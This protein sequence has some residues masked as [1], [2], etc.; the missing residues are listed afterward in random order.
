MKKISDEEH[1]RNI[2]KLM[3]SGTS[4]EDVQQIH[5]NAKSLKK[6]YSDSSFVIARS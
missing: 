1:C 4:F 6:I 2:L 3:P 5:A